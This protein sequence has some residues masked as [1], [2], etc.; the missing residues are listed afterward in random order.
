MAEVHAETRIHPFP[1]PAAAKA[2]MKLSAKLVL[3][4]L[5]LLPW[6]VG[7][8]EPVLKLFQSQYWLVL[9]FTMALLPLLVHR[10]WR[11]PRCWD[12]WAGLLLV[13]Y[14]LVLSIALYRSSTWLAHVSFCVAAAIVG[15]VL[16]PSRRTQFLL[17]L[18]TV[19]AGLPPFLDRP[20]RKWLSGQLV[21]LSSAVTDMLQIWHYREGTLLKTFSA[22]VDLEPA[23]NSPLGMSGLVVLLYAWMAFR[24]QSSA[25]MLVAIPLASLAGVMTTAGACLLGLRELTDGGLLLTLVFWLMLLAFTLL[26]LYSATQLAEFLTHSITPEDKGFN[27]H[28]Q[29]NAFIQLW[30]RCISGRVDSHSTPI[31]IF[32][33][34]RVRLANTVRPLEFL[35]ELFF[36]RRPRLL[37]SAA[38][39]FLAFA[40]LLVINGTLSTWQTSAI[41]R[42]K[43]QAESAQ[44]RS[45]PDLQEICLRGLAA[46]EPANVQWRL[47]LAAFLW[48]HRGTESG[49]REY[50]R[51]A[52]MPGDGGAA[53]HLWIARNAMS[54]TPLY[55]LPDDEIILHLQRSRQARGYAAESHALLSRV[56]IRNNELTLAGQH[57]RSA[58]DADIRY[59]AELITFHRQHQVPMAP[60]ER[61]PK[62]IRQL[63]SAVEQNPKNSSARSELASLL[64]A[65]GDHRRAMLTVNE[66]RRLHD[67][68]ELQELAAL[69]PSEVTKASSPFARPCD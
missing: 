19:L 54:P 41:A 28:I 59:L 69:Q 2:T 60:D 56:Y 16:K 47:Q 27:N 32:A 20:L 50:E 61:I 22:G 44:A 67:S 62:R 31:R 53:A 24:R 33:A 12:R 36:S 14:V 21:Q 46:L 15:S 35:K 66:G 55:P 10:I 1:A 26:L 13:L 25:K 45:E 5:L 43:A 7:G 68:A 30:D 64:Q 42:Y 29:K 8:G 17:V 38:P 18:P 6:L 9:A 34:E 65:V 40:A 3:C 57:I 39:A 58:A 48:D 51:L 52:E 37:V 49:W 63:Q 4:L 11:G 23:L